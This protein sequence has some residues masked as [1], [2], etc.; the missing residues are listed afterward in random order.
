MV[1]RN[2]APAGRTAREELDDVAVMLASYAGH[3]GS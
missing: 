2:V 3:Q 1:N